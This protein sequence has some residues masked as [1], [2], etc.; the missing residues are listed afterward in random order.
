MH[1]RTVSHHGIDYD[2]GHL[3]QRLAALHWRCRDSLVR[4][5]SIRIRFADHCYTEKLVGPPPVGAHC[6]L[7]PRD[8][9][10]FHPRRHAMSCHLPALMDHFLHKPG[11]SIA[12]T[13]RHNWSTFVTALPVPLS[14][15]EKYFIFMTIR[16]A[17]PAADPTGGRIDLFIESAYPRTTRVKVFE[18]K[19][20]GRVV[21]N[22]MRAI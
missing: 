15:G 16:P 4:E 11:S 14:A 1:R 13:E 3:G 19:P 7:R 21:E 8:P 17:P 12:Q 20:F 10:I 9:R 6:I 2:L 18:Q 22:L 5:F